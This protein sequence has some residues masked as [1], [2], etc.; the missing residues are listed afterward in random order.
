MPGDEYEEYYEEE[1]ETDGLMDTPTLSK[2]PFLTFAEISHLEMLRI[3]LSKHI[4]H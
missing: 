3:G 1:T 2:P 4:S